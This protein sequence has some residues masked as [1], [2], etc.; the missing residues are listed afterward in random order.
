MFFY[1][2]FINF[3]IGQNQFKEWAN[4]ISNLFESE[5]SQTYYTPYV[6][7]DSKRI[8]PRGTLIEHFEYT[9]KVLRESKL[10][11]ESL[12]KINAT[13][14]SERDLLLTS[15]SAQVTGT[16]SETP[17]MQDCKIIFLI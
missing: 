7:T 4:N 12:R 17:F 2:L 13:S 6:K 14:V 10:L 3:R 8:S 5:V 1:V 11:T 9:K 16:Y 15:I